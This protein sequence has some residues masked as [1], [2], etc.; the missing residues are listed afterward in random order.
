MPASRTS[1]SL[2][3]SASCAFGVVACD[4]DPS[5]DESPAGDS[6]GDSDAGD[7]DDGSGDA[8]GETGE[9][10]GG[11]DTAADDGADTS[12]GDTAD[13]GAAIGD[14][15]FFYVRSVDDQVDEVWAYDVVADTSQRAI[16]FDSV[17]EVSSLAIHPDRNLLAVA[18][19]YDSIDYQM[20][21]SIYAFVLNE[22]LELGAPELLMEGWAKPIGADK[23]YAQQVDELRWHP[24]GSALWFGHAFRFSV[25]EP[26]G[27]ALASLD[28]A[29]GEY[30]LYDE[31]IDGCTVNT[32]PSPSPDGSVLL[33]VRAVCI[34]DAKE[35]IV[36]FDVPLTAQ[37]EVVLPSSNMVFSAPRWLPDGMGIVFASE[38]DYDSDGDGTLDAFG[39]A[40]LL[41]DLTDGAQYVLV[42]PTPDEYIWDFT[43][44]PDGTRFVLC[45]SH[46]GV[47]DLLLADFSS[48]EPSARWL[49]NDGTSCT[50]SW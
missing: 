20:S 27:G 45:M 37:A 36:A 33:A 21:E 17:A 18:S 32:G 30:E 13:D 7:D 29:S 28:P 1:F 14:D 50:P 34:E 26:G 19:D 49:T 24:D 38:I 25:S 31:F 10:D 5:S 35:G 22:S 40:L 47:R 2:L 4:S 9:D 41:L 46:G 16:A 11:E 6:E 15:V 12:S 3:L 48:D 39:S 44:A 23:G 8:S 43:M 42:P